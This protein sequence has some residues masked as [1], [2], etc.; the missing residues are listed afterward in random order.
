LSVVDKQEE[1]GPGAKPFEDNFGSVAEAEFFYA[2][3]IFSDSRV[4][5]GDF[6]L[7]SGNLGR[8]LKNVYGLF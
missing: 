5:F 8:V 4:D 2:R 6:K 1:G 7:R 3:R